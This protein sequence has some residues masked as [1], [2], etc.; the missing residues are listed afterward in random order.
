MFQYPNEFGFSPDGRLLQNEYANKAAS[1]GTLVIGVTG[2]NS[3]ILLMKKQNSNPLMVS[4]ESDSIQKISE[5]IYGGFSGMSGDSR[6]FVNTL[7]TTAMQ[8]ERNFGIEPELQQL[9]NQSLGSIHQNNFMNPSRPL[10]CSFLLAGPKAKLIK[11]ST[12]LG[13]A[14]ICF[15]GAIGDG[16]E[17]AEK[18]LEE[19][20]EKDME[21]DSIQ[22]LAIA[23]LHSVDQNAQY[24]IHVVN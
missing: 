4:N 23:A 1:R 17:I 15:A 16:A 5:S 8:N 14:N 11:G 9:V 19:H 22:N 7:R 24:I 18:Y 21:N 10:G 13:T 12:A 2:K 3:V 20:F 6:S